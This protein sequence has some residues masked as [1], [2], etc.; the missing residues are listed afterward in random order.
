ML[1]T[2]KGDIP[3]SPAPSRS[4]PRL[5]V[6]AHVHERGKRTRACHPYA[7]ESVCLKPLFCSVFFFVVGFSTK[8][9]SKGMQTV[10]KRENQEVW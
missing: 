8:S 9:E 5:C 6:C 3:L 1:R 7:F 2:Y 10:N 4:H